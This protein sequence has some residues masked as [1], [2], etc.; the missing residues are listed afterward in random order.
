MGSLQYLNRFV[1]AF[2]FHY[3]QFAHPSMTGWLKCRDYRELPHTLIYGPSP[4]LAHLYADAFIQ[5]QFGIASLK[6]QSRTQDM[7]FRHS[8]VSISFLEHPQF[9]EFNMDTAVQNDRC[10][11]QHILSERLQS[12]CVQ[13]GEKHVIILHHV[14]RMSPASLAQLTGLL[15]RSHNAFF[16]MTCC[17]TGAMPAKM[18][19]RCLLV[20][21]AMHGFDAFAT[22]FVR[23]HRPDLCTSP[24][25]PPWIQRW[26]KKDIVKLCMLMELSDPA[27]YQDAFHTFIETALI[28]LQKACHARKFSASTHV[29]TQVRELVSV[30]L[31]TSIPFTLVASSVLHFILQHK[32]DATADVVAL[33]AETDHLLLK[34]TKHLFAL[35]RFFMRLAERIAHLKPAL[36]CYF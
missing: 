15:M 25:M 18:K 22:R 30:L 20:S 11:V 17:K 14:D 3:P 29:Y 12:L 31:K 6:K 27:T 32:P 36:S 7:S 35:E 24:R 23:N 21:S 16:I 8:P 33:C 5:H 2:S 9:T 34:S 4:F 26:V 28:A 1:E 13:P 10:I 19:S